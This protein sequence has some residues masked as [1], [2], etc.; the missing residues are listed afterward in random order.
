MIF[1][2]G[3]Y[4]HHAKCRFIHHVGL[5][6]HWATLF[7]LGLKETKRKKRMGRPSLA[8]AFYAFRWQTYDKN[9]AS[10]KGMQQGPTR[11]RSLESWQIWV[12]LLLKVPFSPFAENPTCKPAFPGPNPV[13]TPT[14]L[15]LASLQKAQ[16]LVGSME[17]QF[18]FPKG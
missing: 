16:L 11:A 13:L 15:P 12:W 6:V 4:C 5:S 1:W 18:D 7:C 14:W 17:N 8:G 3:T 10:I 9:S 2:K